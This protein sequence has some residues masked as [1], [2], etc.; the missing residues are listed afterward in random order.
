ME[1]LHGRNVLYI[2]LLC[3]YYWICKMATIKGWSFNKVN[4]P[5]LKPHNYLKTNLD[6]TFLWNNTDITS[7]HNTDRTSSTLYRYDQFNTLKTWSV[8]IKMTRPFN[9]IQ[10]WLTRLRAM[11]KY[12]WQGVWGPLLKDNL[13]LIAW[14]EQKDGSFPINHGRRQCRL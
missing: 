5:F 11:C 13:F 7:Q 4:R 3:V 1:L 2:T 10:T 9:K 8:D 14:E 6:V 12:I